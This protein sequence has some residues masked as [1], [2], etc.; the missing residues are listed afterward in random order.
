MRDRVAAEKYE[1]GLIDLNSLLN[2]KRADELPSKWNPD[3]ALMLLE[4]G[5]VLQARATP[6]REREEPAGR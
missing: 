4:R 6:R 1:D 5:S 3:D 2:A